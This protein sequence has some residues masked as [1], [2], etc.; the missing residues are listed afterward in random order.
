M[1]NIKNKTCKNCK[2]AYK[3]IYKNSKGSE[4]T[5]NTTF[6][7]RECVSDFQFKNN[8]K[9]STIKILPSKNAIEKEILDFIKSKESYCTTIEV[10]KGIKRSSKSL[11]KLKISIVD[12]NSKL[13]YFKSKSIFEDRVGKILVEYYKNVEFQKTFTNLVGVKGHPLKVDFYIPDLNLVVEADGS[14]HKNINHPWHTSNKN[15]TVK[16]YDDIKNKFML[17]HKIRIVR[18]PYKDIITKKYVLSIINSI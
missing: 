14:Q 1:D 3:N 4:Y 17:E 12:L 8:P 5:L 13:G 15:G 6:C 16:E 9:G 7:S 18:I 11:T 10:L 2:K